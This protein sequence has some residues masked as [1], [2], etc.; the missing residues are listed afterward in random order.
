M[1]ERH[2]AYWAARRLTDESAAGVEAAVVL[3]REVLASRKLIADLRAL[4]YDYITVDLLRQMIG[5]A[6]I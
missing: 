2:V 3:A 6:G 1:P 4:P 5:E